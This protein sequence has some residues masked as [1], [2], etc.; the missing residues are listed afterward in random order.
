V[1]S[2]CVAINLAAEVKNANVWDLEQRLLK[3][4]EHIWVLY[5]ERRDHTL[6]DG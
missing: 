5:E 4:R 2:N 1:Q 3:P 6:Y